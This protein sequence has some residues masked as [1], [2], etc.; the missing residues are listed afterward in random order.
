MRWKL[1]EQEM[2]E[3]RTAI[4]SLSDDDAQSLEELKVALGKVEAKRIMQPSL[5]GPGDNEN[6][7]ETLPGYDERVGTV[8]VNTHFQRVESYQ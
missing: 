8:G 3:I 2:Q 1:L 6:H 5:R 4:G 7:E